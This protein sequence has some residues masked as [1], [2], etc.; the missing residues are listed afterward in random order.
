[1]KQVEVEELQ[2]G[3]VGLIAGSKYEIGDTVVNNDEI[4]AIDRIEVEEPDNAY[5]L[6]N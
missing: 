6:L 2:T 5:D 3:D 1:M 4:E